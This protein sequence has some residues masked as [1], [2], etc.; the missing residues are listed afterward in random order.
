[1]RAIG[2][3]R[4]SDQITQ[5]LAQEGMEIRPTLALHGWSTAVK[6]LTRLIRKY[7]LDHAHYACITG[8]DYRPGERQQGQ[9]YYDCHDT[10]ATGLFTGLAH[11]RF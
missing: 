2:Q 6:A 5:V 8:K 7:D 9:R 4:S 11:C 10:P 1:M 3:Y